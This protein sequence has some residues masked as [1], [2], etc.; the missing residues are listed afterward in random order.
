MQKRRQ[1]LRGLLNNS[2]A[3]YYAAIEIHNKPNVPYRYG[4]TTLLMLNAWELMLKAFVHKYTKKKIFEKDEK[5]ISFR[6]SIDFTRQFLS[7]EDAKFFKPI[8]R[9]LEFLE[10]YRNNYA[11]YYSNDLDTAIFAL[12]AK[13]S[14]NYLDFR[15]KY[16][17]KPSFIDECLYILPLGFKLPF[18]PNI[19]FGMINENED[20]SPEAVKFIQSMAKVTV[21]LSHEG[22]EESIIVG[23]DVHLTSAKSISNADIVAKLEDDG[24][25]IITYKTVRLTN[26]PG[27]AEYRLDDQEIF[28][29]YPLDYKELCDQCSKMIP[30]FKLNSHFHRIRKEYIN[31]LPQF[32]GKRSVNRD[33][34]NGRRYYR[35][36]AVEE[37]KAH[38]NENIY[39]AF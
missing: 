6:K 36:E 19:I 35:K 30:G 20:L 23:F 13:S 10:D 21:D 11:H 7:H 31:D 8:V 39:S 24:L 34:S 4:T 29:I 22:I 15:K 37:I 17:P 38:W 27:A 3:A 1:I 32:S 16:F 14:F 12:L 25:P 5:T 9:N 2:A 26:D 18:N 33:N 28:E